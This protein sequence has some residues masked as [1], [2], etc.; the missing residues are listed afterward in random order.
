MTSHPEIMRELQAWHQS[1]DKVLKRTVSLT[2]ELD[3]PMRSWY[4]LDVQWKE[5]D[6]FYC[7]CLSRATLDCSWASQKPNSPPLPWLYIMHECRLLNHHLG[8]IKVPC[9]R[10]QFSSIR[11]CWPFTITTFTGNE[12]FQVRENDGDCYS[13][14]CVVFYFVYLV[15]LVTYWICS[16]KS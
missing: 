4:Q 9:A 11:S 12:C 2:Y 6:L 14:F 8:L 1:S 10:R 16:K 3:T 13:Y 15:Y 5:S 7:M